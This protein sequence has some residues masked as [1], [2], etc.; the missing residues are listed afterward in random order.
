M[1]FSSKH[2]TKWKGWKSQIYTWEMTH[3]VS[4]RERV[5]FQLILHSCIRSVTLILAST[6]DL[7]NSELTR[8]LFYI[9]QI[10]F[11]YIR[12]NVFVLILIKSKLF[13]NVRSNVLILHFLLFMLISEI[14]FCYF[15]IIFVFIVI[16]I[17]G[18]W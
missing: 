5:T 1:G 15:Y 8:C 16:V 17:V 11:S 18:D 13:L 3:S 12:L 10:Y 14:K 6:M 4:G 2:E 7:K 9:L